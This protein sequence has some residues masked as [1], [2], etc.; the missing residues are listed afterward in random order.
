MSITTG[1]GGSG[2]PRRRPPEDPR[3]RRPSLEAGPIRCHDGARNTGGLFLTAVSY[4]VVDGGDRRHPEVGGRDGQ[5][6]REGLEV[7]DGA[8]LVEGRRVRRPEGADP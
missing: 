8:V 5:S 2:S 4:G 3:Y 1:S 7:H 6:V